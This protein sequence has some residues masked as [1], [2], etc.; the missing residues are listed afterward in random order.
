MHHHPLLILLVCFVLS[1]FF[2]ITWVI[3]MTQTLP[4]TDGAFG[5]APFEEPLVFPIMSI[6]ASIAAIAVY[7]FTYF[8]LRDRQLSKPLIILVG[9]VLAEILLITPLNAFAGFLGSF[10]AYAVA[11]VAARRIFAKSR[12]EPI[13]FSL[14]SLFT[15]FVPFSIILTI[16]VWNQSPRAPYSLIDAARDGDLA[17]VKKLLAE[18]ADVSARDSWGGSALMHASSWGHLGI[19]K[20]LLAQGACIN[21]RSSENTTPLM[22]AASSGQFSVVQYLTKQG[23][24]LLLVDVEGKSAADFASKQGY[25]AITNYLKKEEKRI[26]R[27]VAPAQPEESIPNNPK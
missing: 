19:V 25:T 14:L 11:L 4:S 16:F 20:E 7:P 2:A 10:F 27:R 24:D 13:R 1:F 12:S 8:S 22:C 15:L 5:Q 17:M 21:E 3:V 18:G 23:A 26:V 6:F 9:A